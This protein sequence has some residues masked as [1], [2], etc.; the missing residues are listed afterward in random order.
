MFPFV[1]RTALRSYPTFS[2]F[3]VQLR[4]LEKKRKGKGKEERKKKGK[5]GEM[6]LGEAMDRKNPR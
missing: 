2:K 4:G 3:E 5:E 6:M 1:E